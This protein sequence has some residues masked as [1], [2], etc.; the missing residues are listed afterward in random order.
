LYFVSCVESHLKF[1]LVLNLNELAISKIF[2]NQKKVSL[3]QNC[4]GSKPIASPTGLSALSLTRGPAGV[5]SGPTM[6][7][8]PELPYAVTPP[9]SVQSATPSHRP[10]TLVHTPCG[11]RP[12]TS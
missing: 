6:A 11:R 4:V 8:L 12:L 1:K 9:P 2:E 5:A 7:Q 10:S 3:S